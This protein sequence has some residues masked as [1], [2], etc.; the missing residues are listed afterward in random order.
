MHPGV[1]ENDQSWSSPRRSLQGF[2]E[3]SQLRDLPLLKRRSR[4][5]ECFGYRRNRYSSGAALLDLTLDVRRRVLGVVD[6]GL[7]RA[8]LYLTVD[9]RFVGSPR[10]GPFTDR[11]EERERRQQPQPERRSHAFED[12]FG[13]SYRCS[14][15]RVLYL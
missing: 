1:S 8:S 10:L 6:V 5:Y 12:A 15:V 9:R 11:L 14:R 7:D 2:S 13:G 4:R 3:C